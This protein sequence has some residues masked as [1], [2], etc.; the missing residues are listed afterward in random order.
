MEGSRNKGFSLIELI[1]VVAIMAVLIGVLAPQ[2][3]KYVEKSRV[4]VDEDTADTL[5]GVGYLI[6]SDESYFSDVNI[7]DQII[8]SRSGIDLQ[9]ANDPNLTNALNEFIAGWSSKQVK[10]K[11]Y[12]NQKYVVEFEDAATASGTFM[13]TGSWQPNP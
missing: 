4:S 10:S 5:L 9:P 3:I 11:T 7:G 1:I 8:F 12:H 6:A 13:V 2:Y